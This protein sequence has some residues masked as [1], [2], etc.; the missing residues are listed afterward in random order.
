MYNVRK[1]ST[2]LS[3]EVVF[4][5][6]IFVV[7]VFVVAVFVVVVFVV[8]IFVVVVFGVVVVILIIIIIIIIIVISFFG[9]GN[10][11]QTHGR[12]DLKTQT[13]KRPVERKAYNKYSQL[14][15]M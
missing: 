5:L 11:I 13:A 3:L 7:V 1:K 12:C 6:V 8:V 14:G 2:S 10:N 4:D 9:R 15:E